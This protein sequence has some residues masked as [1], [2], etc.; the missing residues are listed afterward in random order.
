MCRFL[1]QHGANVDHM[2]KAFAIKPDSFQSDVLL[3]S[4]PPHAIGVYPDH[5]ISPYENDW[6]RLAE[7]RKVILESDVDVDDMDNETFMNTLIWG[8]VVS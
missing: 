6:E 4:F 5:Q 1:L 7:C 2:G 3:R 8:R